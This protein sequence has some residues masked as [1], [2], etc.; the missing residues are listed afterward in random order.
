M[1][2]VNGGDGRDDS[3]AGLSNFNV[4]CSSRCPCGAKEGWAAGRVDF[5]K[6][7]GEARY[8]CL[9]HPS[10]QGSKQRRGPKSLGWGESGRDANG[11]QWLSRVETEGQELHTTGGQRELL[12][13]RVRGRACEVKSEVKCGQVLKKA[14]WGEGTGGA[15]S[16]AEPSSRGLRV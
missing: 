1:P 12:L 4:P 6:K 16:R 15:E 5:W 13:W 7:E 9:E 10:G 3:S 2:C 11:C 14:G 8:S